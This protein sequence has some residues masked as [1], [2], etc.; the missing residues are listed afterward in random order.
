MPFMIRRRRSEPEERS[1]ERVRIATHFS[2]VQ[3]EL[4]TCENLLV[5]DGPDWLAQEYQELVFDHPVNRWA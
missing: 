4:P 2:E 5:A 1:A 3:T